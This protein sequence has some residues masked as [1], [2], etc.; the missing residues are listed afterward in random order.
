MESLC[1]GSARRA[2]AQIEHLPVRQKRDLVREPGKD[3]FRVRIDR[4]EKPRAEKKRQLAVFRGVEAHPD[5]ASTLH[6]LATVRQE[7]G[8]NAEAEALYEQAIAITKA[9]LGEAH[10]HAILALASLAGSKASLGK[11]EETLPMSTA[12]LEAARSLK[13]NS[14]LWTGR[15]HLKWEHGLSEAG[16]VAEARKAVRE[17]FD[18][19]EKTL[20]RKA[21]LTTEAEVLHWD[22]EKR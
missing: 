12:A 21:S 17:A 18:L 1:Y 19:L 20:G 7:M 15:M 2:P 4:G 3:L 5:T 13:E 10:P 14:D 11:L 9:A 8:R 6:N 22:I 16:H